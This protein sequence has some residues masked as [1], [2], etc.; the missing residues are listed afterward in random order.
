MLDASYDREP[1]KTRLRMDKLNFVSVETMHTC[2]PNTRPTIVGYCRTKVGSKIWYACTP[3]MPR[4]KISMQYAI[5]IMACQTMT[6]W[7][8]ADTLANFEE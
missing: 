7:A 8:G 3:S 5:R 2:N 6:G 4:H 1:V